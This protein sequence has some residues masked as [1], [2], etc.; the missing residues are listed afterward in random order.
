[1]ETELLYETPSTTGVFTTFFLFSEVFRK[2][3]KFHLKSCHLIQRKQGL[4]VV[5]GSIE[6]FVFYFF[7]NGAGKNDNVNADR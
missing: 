5:C 4:G 2:L 1:M 3:H 7:L 6:S